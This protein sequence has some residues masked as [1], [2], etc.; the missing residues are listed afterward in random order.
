M[1]MTLCVYLQFSLY[2]TCF[3]LLRNGHRKPRVDAA[4]LKSTCLSLYSLSRLFLF[5]YV[6]RSLEQFGWV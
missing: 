1:P 5:R 6:R 2:T 3:T 4:F